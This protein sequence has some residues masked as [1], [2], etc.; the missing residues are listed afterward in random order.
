VYIPI[1]LLAMNED[2]TDRRLEYCEWFEGMM[3]HDEA[4]AGKVVWSD[5]AQFKLNGTV[6]R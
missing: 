5:E 1:L 4:F 6:N 2:D 3:R